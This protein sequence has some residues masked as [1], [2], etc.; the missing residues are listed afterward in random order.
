MATLNNFI[1]FCS[2]VVLVIEAREARILFPDEI[3]QMQNEHKNYQS[4][5]TIC[6]ENEE[7]PYYNETLKDYQCYPIIEQGPC[8]PN[9]WLVLNENNP[10][11]AKCV[12]EPCD[13]TTFEQV[14]FEGTCKNIKDQSACPPNQEILPD[15]FGIG[16]CGCIEGYLQHFHKNGTYSCYQEYL[17]GPCPIGR[18]FI[19]PENS[20]EL[21]PICVPTECDK[22]ETRF[23]DICFPVPNCKDEEFVRFIWNTNKAECA[24]G[25]LISKGLFWFFQL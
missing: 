19:L 22:N 13:D 21:E 17:Q 1:I 2:I 10:I 18:Q 24:K 20:K 6:N 25:Q 7:M 23:M 4:W 8:E 14:L 3:E 9:H 11:F 15:P 5:L 12:K 16:K